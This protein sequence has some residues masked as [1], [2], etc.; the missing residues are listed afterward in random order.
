MA[1]SR[2]SAVKYALLPAA[3]PVALLVALALLAAPA[4]PA[5]S[6]PAE[7]ISLERSQPGP[8]TFTPA[9]FAEAQRQ[10]RL[11]IVETYADWCAPC[12]IQAPIIA[13]LSQ[14][15]RYRGLVVL[16]VDETTP[17]SVW[18]ALS[19]AGFGQFVVFRGE[20]EIRRGSPLN[21]AQMRA[22]LSS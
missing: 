19:L 17:R 11:I 20:R 2:G 3:L 9:R 10:G 4:H 22:L 16:R 6:I 21:E 1:I 8:E 5:P 14:E 13:R 7:T 15:E 18:R 12:R